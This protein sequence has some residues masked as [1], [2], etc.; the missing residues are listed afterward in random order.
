M[1]VVR[2]KRNGFSGACIFKDA[3]GRS[4]SEARVLPRSVPQAMPEQFRILN[5]FGVFSHNSDV[6]RVGQ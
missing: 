6:D 4:E 3:A 1:A 5:K 2:P